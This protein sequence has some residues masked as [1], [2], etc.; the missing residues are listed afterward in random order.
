MCVCGRFENA[1]RVALKGVKRDGDDLGSNREQ[2]TGIV[3]G[4]LP[5][6]LFELKCHPLLFWTWR[7][8]AAFQP[9]LPSDKPK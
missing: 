5:G 1:P 7:L 2:H 6:G 4:F 9:K 8:L 3:C